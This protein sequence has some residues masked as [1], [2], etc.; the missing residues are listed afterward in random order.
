MTFGN[1]SL[2]WTHTHPSVSFFTSTAQLSGMN[3]IASRSLEPMRGIEVMDKEGNVI[4]YSRK[5]G[6]KARSQ[7]APRRLGGGAGRRGAESIPQSQ[8]AASQ[9]PRTAL[10]PDTAGLP[11]P[12]GLASVPSDPVRFL[13]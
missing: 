12:L 10:P 5:A 8:A 11:S 4:G 13:G 7:R 6:T 9:T 1:M 3:V 2:H